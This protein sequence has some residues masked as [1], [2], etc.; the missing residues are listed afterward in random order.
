MEFSRKIHYQH[1][2]AA[3]IELNTKDWITAIASSISD[4]WSWKL[5]FSEDAK[6]LENVLVQALRAIPDEAMKLVGTGMIEKS[7]FESLN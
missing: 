4:E 7:Y 6:L 5:D 3:M 2:E 1:W